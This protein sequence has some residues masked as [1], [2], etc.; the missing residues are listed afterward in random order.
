MHIRL[1]LLALVFGA[2]VLHA[3]EEIGSTD[4][5]SSSWSLISLQ[6]TWLPQANDFPNWGV[7]AQGF[8]SIDAQRRWFMGLGLIASGVERRDCISLMA[9]PAWFFAGD[10]TLGGFVF[11]QGGI[12]ISAR[13]G[14][15]GFNPFSDQTTVFGLGAASGLGGVVEITRW[16]RAQIAI[17]GNAYNVDG[18]R[19][20][21]G[22]QIGISSGGR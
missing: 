11:V 15:T 22:I 13:S 2:S 17:V 7:A 21:Y 10:R 4:S 6:R 9:G 19:T 3:Q 16:I 1:L 8:T 12:V 18:G 5:P 20:P 14:A